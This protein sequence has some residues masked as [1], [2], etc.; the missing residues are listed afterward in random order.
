MGAIKVM[1]QLKVLNPTGMLGPIE[2]VTM[3][4]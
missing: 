3:V 1:A 4:T 2:V